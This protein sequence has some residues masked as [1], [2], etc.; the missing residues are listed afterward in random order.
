MVQLAR[1]MFPIGC[2]AKAAVRGVAEALA[3]GTR[4][5]ADSQGICFLG[6]V[7]FSQFVRAHLGEAEGALLEAESGANLGVHQGFW[8][9]TIGQRWV[10]NDDFGYFGYFGFLGVFGF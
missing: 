2:L 9:H 10:L 5:R 7:H 4:A 1:V 3:L 6:K 8:F